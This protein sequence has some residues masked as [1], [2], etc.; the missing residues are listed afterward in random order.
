MITALLFILWW[1]A[2]IY[3]FIFWWTT[4]HD[5]TAAELP[6]AVS[7]GLMGPLAFLVGWLVHGQRGPKWDSVI[8]KKKMD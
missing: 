2:G 6:I 1:A 4:Q 7:L 8:F 5:F 3:G